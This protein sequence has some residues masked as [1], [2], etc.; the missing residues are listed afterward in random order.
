[1]KKGDFIWGGVLFLIIM[2]LVMSNTKALF[3]TATTSHPYIMGFLKFALLASMGEILAVRIV[4]GEY[5]ISHQ[6]IYKAFVWGFIGVI[7]VVIFKIFSVGVFGLLDKGLLPFKD[8]NL[9]FAF[10][11]S[12]L[13]NITFA[14][15]MMAFHRITDTFIELKRTDKNIKISSALEKIEWKTFIE[16]VLFKTIPLFWIP[17]HTITFLLPSEYRVIMAAFLSIAL[18]AILA[19][20]KKNP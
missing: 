2:L 6:F 19:I 1:M 4:T 7:I 14:P 15:T 10:F 12:L 13:M 11:T 5:S 9:S 18:G 3:L 20:A 16:F 17:A 8:N